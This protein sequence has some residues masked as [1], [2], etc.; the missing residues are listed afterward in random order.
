M[1]EALALG[2]ATLGKIRQ[3][4]AWAG[5]A[6]AAGL[7]RGWGSAW[8]CV[9]VS[10]RLRLGCSPDLPTARQACSASVHLTPPHPAP[11][12][13]YNF[14]GVPVAAGA[15]LPAWG[16]ALSPSLA[17][18]LMALSSIAVVSNSLSLRWLLDPSRKLG[19]EPG[20]GAPA[21]VAAASGTS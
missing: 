14:V 4:L 6:A 13:A 18:G 1:D 19:A 12:V 9:C 8:E 11:A 20:A 2:R 21:P 15:L 17:G 16:V 3:N 7:S 5:E 10:A